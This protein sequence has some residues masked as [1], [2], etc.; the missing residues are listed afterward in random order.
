MNTDSFD[1]AVEIKIVT[2]Q[3]YIKLQQDNVL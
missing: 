3:Q 2:R 1:L